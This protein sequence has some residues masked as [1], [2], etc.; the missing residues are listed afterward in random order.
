MA[1]GEWDAALERLLD[2]PR[3]RAKLAK[4]GRKWARGHAMSRNVKRWEDA[5]RDAVERRRARA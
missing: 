3:E 5:L 2:S 1:D 4:R